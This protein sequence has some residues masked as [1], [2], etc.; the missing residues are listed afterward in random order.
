MSATFGDQPGDVVTSSHGDVA[1]GV[2]LSLH[3]TKV[4]AV[5][6][7]NVLGTVVTN[8]LGRWEFTDPSLTVVWVR[9]PGGSVWSVEDPASLSSTYVPAQMVFGGGVGTDQ[10]AAAL[11]AI[12]AASTGLGGTVHFVGDV[13]ATVPLVFDNCDVT[14]DGGARIISSANPAVQIGGVTSAEKRH[15]DIPPILRISSSYGV[16]DAILVSRAYGCQIHIPTA[17]RYATGLHLQGNT[18]G[19]SYNTFFFGQVTSDVTNIKTSRVNGGWSTQNTFVGG[20]F[21]FGVV[22][23]A[24]AG[25]RQV[26]LGDATTQN[27]AGQNLFL[28]CSFEGE[29]PEWHLDCYESDNRFVACRW[30]APTSGG[31]RVRWGD[32]GVGTNYAHGNVIEGGHLA[33]AINVT[34]GPYARNNV[35]KLPGGRSA[36]TTLTTGD[37]TCTSVTRANVNTATDL[38]L[39]GLCAG[40]VIEVTA[41]GRWDSGAPYVFMDAITI[42]GGVFANA[43]SNVTGFD[44]PWGMLG[45]GGPGGADLFFSGTQQYTLQPGDLAAGGILT[46]RLQYRLNSAGTRILSASV[47]VPLSFSA[48]V[49]T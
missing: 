31:A 14:H 30:E 26:L 41:T 4:D 38:T 28:G 13:H 29:V 49:V 40:Q 36:K 11:A 21:D 3:P 39:T 15:I 1:S 9:D 35:I 7:S 32:D 20:R 44:T 48:R 23:S 33:D 24:V 17:Y 12:A 25:T 34:S 5:A 16:G 46:L 43:I 2:S 8:V 22:G 27:G 6:G 47:N 19:V 37:L 45:W 10:T 18:V 42:V